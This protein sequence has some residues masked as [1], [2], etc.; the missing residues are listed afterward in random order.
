MPRAVSQGRGTRNLSDQTNLFLGIGVAQKAPT[1]QAG[2]E[3]ALGNFRGSA[4]L[5]SSL[6]DVSL[7]MP[8]SCGESRGLPSS[9]EINP[10]GS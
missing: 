5:P 3:G 8:G 4:W 7:P 2:E 10:L 1:Q 9:K 6:Q